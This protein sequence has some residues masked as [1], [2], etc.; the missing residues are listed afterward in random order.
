MLLLQQAVTLPLLTQGAKT[1]RGTNAATLSILH[2]ALSNPLLNA[3]GC[4]V[5][6]LRYPIL[7]LHD[8]EPENTARGFGFLPGSQMTKRYGAGTGHCLHP[9]LVIFV[10]QALKLMTCSTTK[11]PKQVLMLVTKGFMSVS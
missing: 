10:Q 7:L 3:W 6:F 11:L 1:W 8:R 2:A 9:P 5:T 4:W